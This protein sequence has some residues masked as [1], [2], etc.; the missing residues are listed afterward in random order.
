MILAG[1]G[2]R[3]NK[4]GGYSKAAFDKLVQIAEDYLK[5]SEVTKVISGMALGWDQALA[6]AAINC[7]IP[8]LAAVPFKGQEI[9]WPKESRD[10]FDELLSKAIEVVY[11]SSPGYDAYKM[12]VRNQYMI[13]NCDIVLTVYDGTPGG[14]HNCLEYAKL[15]NKTIVNLYD[16]L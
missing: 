4:L 12:Q 7:G 8:F 11:V 1:T 3:P 5:T 15:Y 13:D 10:K 14:T 6:Q 9:M 16:K 2:H